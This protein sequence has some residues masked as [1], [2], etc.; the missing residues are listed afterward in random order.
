[1]RFGLA[2]IA[3]GRICWTMDSACSNFPIRPMRNNA[4]KPLG[5]A[6]CLDNATEGCDVPIPL[7]PARRLANDLQ[8]VLVCEIPDSASSNVR[9]KLNTMPQF[10]HLPNICY[11]DK[12]CDVHILVTISRNAKHESDLCEHAHSVSYVANVAQHHNAML[13]QLRTMVDS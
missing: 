6:F 4:T 11:F 1:M 13:K 2:M 12:G 10:E 9:K 8:Y 7:A 3:D 5:A